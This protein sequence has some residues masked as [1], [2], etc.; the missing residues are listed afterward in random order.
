MNDVQVQL[1]KQ[2]KDQIKEDEQFRE[3]MLEDEKLKV[4]ANSITANLSIFVSAFGLGDRTGA[5]AAWSTD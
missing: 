3:K 2:F 1:L 5:K 4:S